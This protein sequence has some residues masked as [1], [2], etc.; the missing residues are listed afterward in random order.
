MSPSGT[1]AQRKR[2]TRRLWRQPVGAIASLR[3]AAIV[4]TFQQ[5]AEEAIDVM[6][7]AID[8]DPRA[9]ASLDAVVSGPLEDRLVAVLNGVAEHRVSVETAAD[10]V[11]ELP[12]A[13][14]G[15]ARVDHHRELR[16]GACEIVYGQGKTAEQLAAIVC[17][18]LGYNAGSVI[19]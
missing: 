3:A 18:L 11:R 17:R 16:Q 4:D 7:P 19:V 12:L 6:T 5:V 8:A 10:W 15:F 9:G 13:D 1:F 2:T 14:L